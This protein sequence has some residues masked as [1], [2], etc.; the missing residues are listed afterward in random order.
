M[1]EVD[2]TE[3]EVVREIF[4]RYAAG[5]SPRAIAATLNA[6]SLPGPRGGAWN[7]STINGNAARGNGVLHNQLYRGQLVWGRHRWTKSR[8]TGA[9]Q[10][11]A[12]AASEIVTTEVTHLRI[13]SEAQWANV[14]QRYADVALGP[15]NRAKDS[16]RPRR[17]LSGLVRCGCCRGPMSVGGVDSRLVCSNRRERGPAICPEGRSVRSDLVEARVTAAVQALLLDPAAVEAAIR[18]HQAASGRAEGPRKAS[19][20]GMRRSWL[21]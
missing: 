13:V 19:D 7:A 5:F 16:R 1:R 17:L 6:R 21:R 4:D 20:R 12:G 14:Q 11:R 3:A 8:E 10:A 18:E 2:P 15:Q 9:R